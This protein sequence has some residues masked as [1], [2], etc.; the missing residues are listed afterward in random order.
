M[1]GCEMTPL[2]SLNACMDFIMKV[3]YMLNTA[4]GNKHTNTLNLVE[5]NLFDYSQMTGAPP[6]R[7]LGESRKNSNYRLTGHRAPWRS[8]RQLHN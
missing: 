6:P 3:L 1:F 4:I 7:Q 5:I 8:V 2:E